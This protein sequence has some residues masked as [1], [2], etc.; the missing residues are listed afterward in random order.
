MNGDS[1]DCT[2]GTLGLLTAAIIYLQMEVVITDKAWLGVN[3]QDLIK[4]N[5]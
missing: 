4:E 3:G 2:T 5:V 1:M